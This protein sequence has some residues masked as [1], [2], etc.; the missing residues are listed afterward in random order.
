MLPLHPC[1]M[2]SEQEETYTIFSHT[3]FQHGIF[4]GF[5]SVHISEYLSYTNITIM[6][7]QLDEKWVK[8]AQYRNMERRKIKENY[9]MRNTKERSVLRS[10]LSTSKLI[11]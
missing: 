8:D 2:D 6:S 1:N 5:I 10:L 9:C 4:I 11:R 7:T 3:V